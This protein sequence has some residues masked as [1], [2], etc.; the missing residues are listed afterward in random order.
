MASALP[1]V[2]ETPVAADDDRLMVELVSRIGG[3]GVEVAD[4]AGNVEQVTARVAQQAEQF[5]RLQ[6][7]VEE[8]V[9][10]NRRIDDAAH[11]LR[12][13]A[14]GSGAVIAK[15]SGAV[16]SAATDIGTL[17]EAVGRIEE[18]LS[19]LNDVLQR[20][21]DISATI[22]AI[23]RQ[24]NLLALNAT[25]EAAR[26]GAAGKGFQVVATEVKA[27]ANQTRS[28]TQQI[29]QTVQDLTGRVTAL[30]DESVTASSSAT[31]VRE[32]T[33][34]VEASIAGVGDSFA[35]VDGEIG[36]IAE[37][38]GAN[39]AKCDM[40]LAELGELA[41]GVD[42]SAANLR[43]ADKR[44][45]ALLQLSDTLVEHTAASGKRIP[46]SPFIDAVRDAASHA[47]AAFEAALDKGE[48]T[49]DALF[50]EKYREVP[51]SDPTQH[52]TQ[53]VA[54]TDRVMPAIQE[55]LLELD[56]RVVFCAA[57]DRNGYLPTHN[58]KFSQSQGKDPV[59]NAANCRNRRIFN[60]RT[61]LS[62][63]RNT[64]P[65]LLQTY[66]R[67]MG[68]GKFVLMKDVSAPITVRGRHWGGVRMGYRQQ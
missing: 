61:G 6:A 47:A 19:G 32:G 37:T 1:A 22:E 53:F 45:V 17:I 24:T 66:R 51:G 36:G 35:T 11:T 63:G 14:Q 62:A 52:M 21:T 38:T 60:D 27:L 4:V 30:I 2:S 40:V 25:I 33:T 49:L 50:D 26:A 55:P 57:V 67:D 56:A 39:L 15:S 9:A 31:R 16:H 13:A 44:L 42:L 43:D 48:I 54:L 64:K 5:K 23:A 20:V 58:R 10:A 68:G 59:W 29:D 28:A 34:L 3:L 18:R 8:M 12:A 41:G 7:A 65:F 46:D